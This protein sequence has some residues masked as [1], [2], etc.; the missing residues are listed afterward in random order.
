MAT[1]KEVCG[2]NHK[3]REKFVMRRLRVSQSQS[4]WS[5]SISLSN[6]SLSNTSS[7]DASSNNDRRAI[8]RNWMN[9]CLCVLP[10]PSA[11]LLG[12]DK[13]AARNCSAYR[14]SL[15]PSSRPAIWW[16]STAR[17]Q[18]LFQICRSSNRQCGRR[19]RT[20][21]ISLLLSLCSPLI[22]FLAW[23]PALRP[24]RSAL[25]ASIFV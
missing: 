10:D 14:Y 25:A 16:K 23:L 5:I 15:R 13:H 18:A 17:S 12:S 20:P 24:V 19:G 11:M 22:L 4:S 7:M 6:S 21:L 9:S 1:S 2:R 8:L 3:E